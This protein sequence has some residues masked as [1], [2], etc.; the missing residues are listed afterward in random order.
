MPSESFVPYVSGLSGIVRS[1][2][3][4]DSCVS[5]SVRVSEFRKE[6]VDSGLFFVAIGDEQTDGDHHRR[7]DD[8]IRL[9]PRSFLRTTVLRSDRRIWTIAAVPK[10]RIIP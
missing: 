10:P 5:S 3:V 4:H 6:L 7:I 9:F 2:C 8:Q 1:A